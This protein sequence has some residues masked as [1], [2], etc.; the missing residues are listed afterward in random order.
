ML[1]SIKSHRHDIIIVVM[2]LSFFTVQLLVLISGFAWVYVE[3]NLFSYWMFVFVAFLAIVSGIV[4]TY[5]FVQYTQ[6]RRFK[7]F[8]I[9][10]LGAN[11]VLLAFL[12]LLTHPVSSWSV[13]SNR[14]RNITIVASM[15]FL[16]TPG[17]LAGYNMFEVLRRAED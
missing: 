2:F 17:V 9:A 12:F 16:I 1:E 13:F 3:P 14:D 4:S 5:S 11:V 15:G 6:E 8:V 7:S 10:L